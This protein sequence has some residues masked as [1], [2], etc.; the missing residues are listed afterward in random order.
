MA[1][2]ALSFLSLST[3]RT[4]PFNVHDE[5]SHHRHH[6]GLNKAL[7]VPGGAATSADRPTEKREGYQQS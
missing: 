4:V 1:P 6:H 7:T 3:R 5:Y 2:F